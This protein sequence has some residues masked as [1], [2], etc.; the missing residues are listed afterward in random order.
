MPY[1]TLEDL[2]K[3]MPG[4]EITQLTD[5]EGTGSVNQPRVDEA[6]ARADAAIDAY[7][8]SRYCVPFAVP[9][10]LIKAI[11]ADLAAYYL[12]SRRADLVSAARTDRYKNAL[13]RLE[14][15]SR[16]LITLV[17]QVV[18]SEGPGTNASSDERL[19]TRESLG[20]Y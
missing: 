19:F 12:C 17:T 15:I 9:P 14:A 4:E 3:I 18:A 6:I 11:S 8:A 16:G 10:A 1:I 2:K 5:D 7:C 13:A 20:G